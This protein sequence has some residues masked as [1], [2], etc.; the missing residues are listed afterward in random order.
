MIRVRTIV[1]LTIIVFLVAT[2]AFVSYHLGHEVVKPPISYVNVSEYFNGR[3]MAFILR[4][5]D[6]SLVCSNENS[7]RYIETA[8]K[9]ANEYGVKTVLAVITRWPPKYGTLEP[10]SLRDEEFIRKASLFNEVASHS[11]WHARSP[12]SIEDVIGGFVDI[13]YYLFNGSYKLLTYVYPFGE[14]DINDLRYMKIFGVPIGMTFRVVGV[15]K[16]P[17][18]ESAEFWEHIPLTRIL[19]YYKL[20]H[21]ESKL[22]SIITNDFIKASRIRGLIIYVTHPTKLNWPNESIMV[23]YLRVMLDVASRFRNITWFTT[24]GELYSYIVI[25]K[26]LVVKLLSYNSTAAI[27]RVCTHD[28]PTRVWK[29]PITLVFRVDEKIGN[30]LAIYVN[31]R[32]LREG[33]YSDIGIRGDYHE[34][35]RFVNNY[36]YVSVMV[37]LNR[38]SMLMFKVLRG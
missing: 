29:I 25:A 27:F 15:L 10:F 35:Y 24:P 26:H 5:D 30:S 2:I 9:L 3:R 20:P 4:Y 32:K 16:N 1:L 33:D 8:V 37:P 7:R 34:F 28:I 38:C 19:S 12:R 21:S 13:E 36:I 22:R 31:H 6:V 11:R 17:W 23:K 14:Y 18:N